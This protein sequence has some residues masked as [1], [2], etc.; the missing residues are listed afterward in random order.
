M[1]K[2]II[3]PKHFVLHALLIL[4][5]NCGGPTLVLGGRGG[6]DSETGRSKYGAKFCGALNVPGLVVVLRF[7]SCGES[8]KSYKATTLRQDNFSP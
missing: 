1:E 3:A 8:R 2:K 6:G 7:F 4:H 5:T